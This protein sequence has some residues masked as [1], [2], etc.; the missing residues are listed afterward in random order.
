M[1]TNDFFLVERAAQIQRLRA[2]RSGNRIDIPR[3]ISR[4]AVPRR[5]GGLLALIDRIG[6]IR[7]SDKRGK[8]RR[9]LEEH[10]G[11]VFRARP[12][13]EPA[14]Q[15]SMLLTEAQRGLLNDF[16]RQLVIVQL[17]DDPDV[18]SFADPVIT[19]IVR[20]E[21]GFSGLK[22]LSYH[23]DNFAYECLFPSW[24]NLYTALVR[25]R[26]PSADPRFPVDQIRTIFR[27]LQ[28][29]EADGPAPALVS[30]MTLVANRLP[31]LE[32]QQIL[33]RL[34]DIGSR[35]EAESRAACH[36][37]I[38]LL[39]ECSPS[40]SAMLELLGNWSL[41]EICAASARS[42]STYKLSADL[43]QYATLP[44]PVVRHVRAVEKVPQQQ[45]YWAGLL[46][47][48]ARIVHEVGVIDA[49]FAQV[50]DRGDVRLDDWLGLLMPGDEGAPLA[51]VSQRL[52]ARVLRRCETRT[53][54][55][56]MQCVHM[57]AQRLAPRLNTLTG[58]MATFFERE[59]VASD[60]NRALLLESAG[61]D[62]RRRA[63]SRQLVTR[64]TTTEEP[65][66]LLNQLLVVAILDPDCDAARLKS[67]GRTVT[68]LQSLREQG[69]IGSNQLEML[70]NDVRQRLPESLEFLAAPY[71]GGTG[72]DGRLAK[73]YLALYEECEKFEHTGEIGNFGLT[74][75]AYG[76][77]NRNID[78]EA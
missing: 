57:F 4:L 43:P 77:L 52:L 13:G 71:L 18:S 31:P 8:W 38:D 29:F 47:K 9:W 35:C 17:D 56:A 69:Y 61:D 41:F 46:R 76:V 68:V 44:E 64:A 37:K 54:G 67:I 40:A 30:A 6:R 12:A 39:C 63:L 32:A 73:L 36:A 28:E 14:E 74:T 3:R 33:Q 11:S 62:S 42:D 70:V 58:S 2:A 27:F 26:T 75:A 53:D 55:P 23:S 50:L 20:D 72:Q 21:S 15:E 22:P 49:E 16:E 48:I 78:R 5:A 1:V 65:T 7:L 59:F 66:R 45:E 51:A 25:P 19:A 60:R 10:A 34:I 24:L